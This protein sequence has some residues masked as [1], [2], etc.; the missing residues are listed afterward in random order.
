MNKRGK[1]EMEYTFT[2]YANVVMCKLIKWMMAQ[3]EVVK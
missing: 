2:C 1:E 3:V